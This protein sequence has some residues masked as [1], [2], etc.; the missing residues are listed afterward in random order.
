M[1]T[2]KDILKKLI[3]DLPETKT[4]QAI[5]FLLYLRNKPEQ[6]LYISVKEEEEVWNLIRTDERVSSNEVKKELDID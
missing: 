4:G 3:A 1:N 2:A 5:D 6:D